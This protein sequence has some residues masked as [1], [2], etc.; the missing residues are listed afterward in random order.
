[1]VRA[2]RP[3]VRDIARHAG[4]SVATVSRVTHDDPRV[5]P[6]TR[7]R[8]RASIDELGY[9]P[10]SLG[11]SLAAG[12]HSSVALV[13]PGLGG[14][15]FAELVQGVESV[16]VE[17]GVTVHVLGTHLRPD[18]DAD[19]RQLAMR[20]DGLLIGGG[21]VSRSLARDLA[22]SLPVVLVADEVADLA[23]VRTDNRRAAYDLTTHLLTVHHHRRLRFVGAFAG[24]PDSTARH[25]GFLAA[26]ADH[27]LAPVAEPLRHGLEAKY[28]AVAAREMV[29]EGS[30]PDAVVCAND[31]LA[32]GLLATLPGL[33]VA[34]P[35]QL[36][37]V[38]FDDLSLAALAA[39]TLTTVHQPIFEL[40]ARAATMLLAARTRPRC[41]FVPLDPVDEVL[42]TDTVVRESC[43]CPP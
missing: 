39:P 5:A 33:G 32:I 28:G 18:S 22:S 1:M 30:V 9:Y 6:E 23:T 31:E 27:G 8:V 16:V 10:S 19:V 4:V 29:A 14:P 24:S 37:I 15:Y 11:R 17:A 26:L 40:G 7:D 36:A 2:T 35:E 20:T 41:E 34:L 42:P 25:E 3:T 12:Q 21:T 38:G 13:L 43:G